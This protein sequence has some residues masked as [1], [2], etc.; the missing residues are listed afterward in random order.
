[1]PPSFYVYPKRR[2]TR[3]VKHKHAMILSY[4]VRSETFRPQDL[5]SVECAGSAKLLAPQRVYEIGTDVVTRWHT[6]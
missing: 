1:M 3:K 4:C 5:F 6:L 2:A